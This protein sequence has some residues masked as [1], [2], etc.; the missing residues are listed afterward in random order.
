[1]TI[2]YGITLAISIV[3]LALYFLLVKN[4]K[5]WLGLLFVCVTVVNLGY[6]LMS[7]ADT[8]GF[9]I[10]ANDISYLGSVFLSTCML[11]TIVKLCGFEIKKSYI[12]TCICLGALMFGIVAT[13]GF[14]PLYYKEVWIEMIDGSAKLMKEYGPLH[15]LYVVYILGYFVAMIITIVHS[16]RLKKIASHKFS[17][18]IAGVVCGNILVWLFE[19]FIHWDF[20]FLSVTYITSE[21]LLLLLYWMMEDYV[22]INDIPK[23]TPAEKMQLGIDILTMPMD[24]KI[25]KVLSYVKDGEQLAHREREVLEMILDN[26]K[27]KEIAAE[28]HLSENTV[29][30]YTRTLYLKLGVTC[31]EELYA[32]LLKR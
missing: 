23:F 17:G 5:L 3:L 12:I 6:F 16:L 15:N 26:K 10:F 2:G 24:I 21:I 7:L 13:S 14:L 22:H 31:R 27:R 29:K 11:M 32:L 19:K 4:R 20:E 1:M 30:T 25:S 9:A 18:L 8:V 28:L